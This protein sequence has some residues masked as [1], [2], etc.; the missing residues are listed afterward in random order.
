MCFPI[1]AEGESFS[2]TVERGGG[3]LVSRTILYEMS[4][5]G[6]I[7]FFGA[8]GLITFNSGENLKSIQIVVVDDDIPEVCIRDFLRSF[9]TQLRLSNS[10]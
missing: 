6:N 1:Q 9:C 8:V 10:L 5:N 7:E 3:D 4:A 2:I